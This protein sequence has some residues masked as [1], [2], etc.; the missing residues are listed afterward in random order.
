MCACFNLYV[1][2]YLCVCV[3]A[4]LWVCIVPT[5][6]G[7]SPF[8]CTYLTLDPLQLVTTRNCSIKQGYLC[9]LCTV[10]KLT[11]FSSFLVVLTKIHNNFVYSLILTTNLFLQILDFLLTHQM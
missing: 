9:T 3:C 4:C 11:I 8:L 1:C 5:D 7:S 6:N 10:L 2:Q